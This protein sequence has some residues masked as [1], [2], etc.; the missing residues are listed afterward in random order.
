MRARSRR[1]IVVTVSA[2]AHVAVL[3]VLA[4]HAPQLT[5]PA[6]EPTLPHAVIPILLLP[7]TPPP[8]AG[9]ADPG[10]IRLHRRPQPYA[11]ASPSVPP[12]HVPKAALEAPPRPPAPPRAE[13]QLPPAVTGQVTQTLRLGTVGCRHADLMKLS[14]QERE[15]CEDQLA[16]GA[17][18]AP[19]IPPGKSAKARAEFQAQGARK[20]ALMRQREAPLGTGNTSVFAD[21]QD[22]DGEPYMSG[23]GVSLFGPPKH[24]PSKRA[25]KQ[26]GPLKP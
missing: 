16:A 22:Y 9:Q 13:P 14:R 3:A 15:A 26:L 25:A 19:W 24:P 11:A 1:A 12:L 4:L 5:M 6:E 17:R 18:D 23:A 8:V 21:P 20:D 10:P 2:A 7:R